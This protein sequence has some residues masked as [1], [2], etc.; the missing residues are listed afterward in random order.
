MYILCI[1]YGIHMICVYSTEYDNFISDSTDLLSGVD[2]HVSCMQQL[3]LASP[4]FHPTGPS[5]V[6]NVHVHVHTYVTYNLL[7]TLNLQQ[8]E[9]LDYL[10]YIG[11][12]CL[13]PVTIDK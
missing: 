12:C 9:E 3:P 2:S 7:H 6:H 10:T 11:C 13:F 1:I 4:G 8:Q 5:C